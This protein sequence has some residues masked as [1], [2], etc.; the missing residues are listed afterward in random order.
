[1]RSYEAMTPREWAISKGWTTDVDGRDYC[2]ECVARY[3][4][5]DLTAQY[6]DQ[7]LSR[8]QM[9]AITLGI[10][11]VI[12]VALG[13]MAATGRLPRNILAGIRI[14]STMRSDEAWIA[15]HRAAASALTVSGLGPIIVAIIVGTKRPDGD[16]QTSIFRVGTAW[17]LAW[18]G[19]ATIQASRAARATNLG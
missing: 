5:L 12:V 2:P 11:G 6:D 9:R 13:R 18:I 10:V 3:P 14:P 7:E 8:S 15:G 1:M 17:L 4:G 19:I 16:T